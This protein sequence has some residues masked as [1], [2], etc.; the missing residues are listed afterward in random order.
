MDLFKETLS[1]EWEHLP[2]VIETSALK[3]VGRQELLSHIASL[4]VLW[5]QEH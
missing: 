1:E 3:D 2:F 4:R 5:E